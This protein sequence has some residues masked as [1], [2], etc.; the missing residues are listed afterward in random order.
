MHCVQKIEENLYYV[1]GS[2]R[3]LAL[4][5]NV[6]PLADGVSYNS[7]LLTDEKTVLIDTVDKS[8]ERLFLENVDYAL[9]GRDLDYLIVNHMEPD[10]AA[11]IMTVLSK[12]EN[13]TLVA[14]KKTYDLFN[15]FFDADVSGRVMI[16]KEG[17]E[18]SVGSHTLTFY[19]A[20]MVHW[21]EV[22]VTYDKKSKILF[23]ADAF[24]T[25]GALS[26]PLFADMV[27]FKEN[28]LTEARRYYTNIVG[29]YGPQVQALLKKAQTLEISA[30]CPL[31]GPIWREDI[32]FFVDK[33]QKWSTYT[34]EEK[35]VLIVYGSIYGHTENAASALAARLAEK[36]VANIKMYD[37]SATHSSYILAEVFKY[38]HIVLA[39]ATFN[40][41]IFVSMD[42]FISDMIS[43]NVQNKVVALAENGSWA[44]TAANLM[45]EKLAKLK[46]ITL[47][48]NVL[49][50]KSSLKKEQ[51]N[52]LESLTNEIL[53]SLGE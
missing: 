6:Y 49:K 36:G 40:N 25:F 7:Y 34:S 50:I 22:T 15:Q 24:G 29:K 5:E 9:N 51:E 3:R 31:H 26:G 44:P 43:H 16:I 32:G 47:L 41:E 39:S 13:A 2:D 48:E 37:A 46:N 12:Y 52:E 20:P 1:G 30:I 19:A 17:D 38:S 23:S 33:Y 35:G 53:A 21:P 8:V 10:H 14:S 28:Y 11:T 18:L 45:R 42:N 4:F 27:S